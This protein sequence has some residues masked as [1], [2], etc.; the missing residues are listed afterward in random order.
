ML[1][2]PVESL[3]TPCTSKLQSFRL[4][5]AVEITEIVKMSK[6]TCTFIL[7]PIPTSLLHDLFPVITD[8]VNSSFAT[9]VFPSELK[10]AIIK[11]RLKKPGLDT[12]VLTN[13]LPVSNL[14]FIS[15][16]IEKVV[17]SRLLDHMV[18]NE[19]LESFQSAYRAGYSQLTG[20][21]TVLKEHS[22]EFTMT[23]KM[24]VTKRRVYFLYCSTSRQHLILLT[25]IF[26]LTFSEIILVWMV[27]SWIYLDHIYLVELYVFLSLESC[28][29]WVS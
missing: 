26:F 13:F 8:L 5:N 25:M 4:T 15:K 23:L 2:P 12:D 10:S 7:D 18:E 20:Q 21:V 19:L 16:V 29:N 17:A 24:L 6:A 27:L 9:G 28:Q 1:C 11:P 3:L 22:W 14:S